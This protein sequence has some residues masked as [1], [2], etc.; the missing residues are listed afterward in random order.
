MAGS[1]PTLAR[2]AEKCEGHGSGG[3]PMEKKRRSRGRAG[4]RS[5]RA[6]SAFEWIALSVWLFAPAVMAAENYEVTVERN[7]AAKMRDGVTLRAD[8]YRPKAEGKFPV[9]LVRTPYDKQWSSGFGHRAAAH[10]YVV[11]A[12]DVRGRFESEGEW[13]TFRYESQDGY[14]TVEWAAGLPYSNGKVGMFGGSYVGATQYLAALAKPP[15]LAGICPN[16]TASNYHDGWTYQGGAFEQ[17]FN[18]SWTTGLAENTM[19]RRVESGQNAIAGAQKLPLSTYPILQTPSTEGLAP[20]FTD[21]LAHP[22]YD[23]YWKQWSI[24]DH[25][26]QIQVPV[27]SQ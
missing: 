9:L 12:Q 21:W 6:W 16:V 25:Y 15:H 7:V 5:N 22:N 8:I 14:D 2:F 4:V 23:E 10:G 24:E 13:Y 20:Y 1:G 3:D 18:E 11:I 26:A 27:F 17:W 19:Q